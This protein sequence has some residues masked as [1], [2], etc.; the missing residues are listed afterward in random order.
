[1]AVVPTNMVVVGEADIL[2]VVEEVGKEAEVVPLSV[3][4]APQSAIL[5]QHHILLDP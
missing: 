5:W 4:R 2:V 1:M 3:E